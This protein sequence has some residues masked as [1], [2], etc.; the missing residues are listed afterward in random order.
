MAR[1]AK[2]PLRNLRVGQSVLIP[3][4]EDDEGNPLKDQRTID[5]AVRQEARRF[6]RQFERKKTFA[7]LRVRRVS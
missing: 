3:W 1:A 7:G 6:N 5:A 4:N 2:Y